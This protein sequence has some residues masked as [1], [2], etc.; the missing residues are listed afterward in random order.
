MLGF[1]NVFNVALSNIQVLNHFLK[2]N[3]SEYLDYLRMSLQRN[4]F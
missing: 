1:P 2:K 3:I 4:T